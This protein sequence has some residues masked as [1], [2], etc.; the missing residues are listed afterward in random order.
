M[1]TINITAKDG[2]SHIV[3]IDKICNFSQSS[4]GTTIGLVNGVNIIT[5][6][7]IMALLRMIK[8]S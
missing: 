6:Y 5:S 8:P 4:T 2:T 7:S 3:F 1:T